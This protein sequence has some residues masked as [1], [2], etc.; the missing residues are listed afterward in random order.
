M[1][2]KTSTSQTN[3]VSAYTI[4]N[5]KTKFVQLYSSVQSRTKMNAA[6]VTRRIL[7]TRSQLDWKT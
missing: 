3:G 1:D 4:P 6:I 2:I 7:I 5:G